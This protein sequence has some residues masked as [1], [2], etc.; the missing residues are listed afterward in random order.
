MFW[1]LS[2]IQKFILI[3]PPKLHVKDVKTLFKICENYGE[4]FSIEKVSKN[5]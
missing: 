3:L 5:I 4:D 2:L 1:C